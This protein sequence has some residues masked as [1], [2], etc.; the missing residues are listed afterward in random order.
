MDSKFGAYAVFHPYIDTIWYRDRLKAVEFGRSR[1]F[2]IYVHGF[3]SRRKFIKLRPKIIENSYYSLLTPAIAP[4]LRPKSCNRNRPSG[5]KKIPSYLVLKRSKVFFGAF[6]AK[7][8]P[9]TIYFPV[10]FRF[11]AVSAK[12]WIFLA[13]N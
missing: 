10:L 7:K 11:Y 4:P 2:L 9:F 5:R 6:G 1:T 3:G 8:Q 13:Q 12:L